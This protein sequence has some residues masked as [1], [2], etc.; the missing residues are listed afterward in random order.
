MRE[1]L[2]DSLSF[3]GRRGFAETMRTWENHLRLEDYRPEAFAGAVERV[4]QSGL[5][6][7]TFAELRAADP[8]FFDKLYDL[9]DEVHL[10]VPSPDQSTSVER[11]RWIEREEARPCAFGLGQLRQ[12]VLE[13]AQDR[14]GV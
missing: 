5:A 9:V 6:L 10:D 12:Q 8:D 11:E 14:Q 13:V 1:D 3:A 2:V 4:E 7:R